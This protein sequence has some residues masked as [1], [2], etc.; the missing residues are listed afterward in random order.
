MP[1]RET[2]PVC[3]VCVW[4]GGGR[5]EEDWIKMCKCEYMNVLTWDQGY[6]CVCICPHDDSVD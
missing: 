4:G 1:A 6:E 5:N 3:C 2:K